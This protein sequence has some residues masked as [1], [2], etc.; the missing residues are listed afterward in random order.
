MALPQ[1]VTG[2]EG[3][4]HTSM[5]EFFPKFPKLLVNQAYFFL[6]TRSAL[7]NAAPVSKS[8]FIIKKLIGLGKNIRGLRQKFP[9]GSEPLCQGL[10]PGR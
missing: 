9:S 2:A 1:E 7:K 3:E 8:P 6:V 10:G 4:I 5:S